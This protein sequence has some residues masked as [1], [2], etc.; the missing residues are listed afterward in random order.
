MKSK[1]YFRVR[2]LILFGMVL[3]SGVNCRKSEEPSVSQ[4]L[5]S[6]LW[7][8]TSDWSGR[9]ISDEEFSI[10]TYKLTGEYIISSN[11]RDE[12][13]GTWNLKEDNETLI[14][15]G[16]DYKIVL[17][18]ETELKITSTA[19]EGI[20][21]LKALTSTIA[22]TVGITA[23]TS[24]S[25]ILNGT[26]RTSNSNTEVT[27]EY[28]TTTSYGKLITATKSPVSGP[29]FSSADVVLSGLI[30]ETTY[31]Y[32]IKVVNSSGTVYGQ[33]N[34][35]KTFT[36]ET[37]TDIDGNVY[38][39]VKIGTQVWMAENLKATKYRNGDP[40]PNITDNTQWENLTTGAYCNYSNDI[41]NVT[42]YGRLYNWYAVN[43]SRTIAPTG[44]H[45]ATD[46]DWS[47]LTGFLGGDKTAGSKL[48]E[49]GSL[50]WDYPNSDAT[51][52]SGF[53]ALPGGDRSFDGTFNYITTLGFWWCSTNGTIGSA[54]GRSMIRGFGNI[55]R[56]NSVGHESSG[57]SVRCVRD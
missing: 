50:H 45:V 51:N 9:S 1:V 27:F 36:A 35:F 33:D 18:T 40:I 47:I 42:T 20:C 19:I 37:V 46:S 5:T 25:V 43:D 55:D 48:K 30:P 21:S 31:H 28:G 26:L 56:Y 54:W 4:L 53:T 38:N 11:I 16:L 6:S 15:N 17:L 57:C 44:W 22:S 14:M 41:K 52:E 32:R 2:I 12:I 29:T 3:M 23:L 49:T 13:I 10:T 8:L 34:S 24:T 7:S 39:T